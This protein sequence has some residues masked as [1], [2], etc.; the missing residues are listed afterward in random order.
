MYNFT[1]DRRTQ[2]VL[3]SACFVRGARHG[4][5]NNGLA[6]SSGNVFYRCTA[7]GSGGSEGGHRQWTT[8][9]LYDNVV[10]ADATAQILFD[11]PA[12]ELW[13]NLLPPTIPQPSLN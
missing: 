12:E 4:F 1:C 7:E 11:T 10:D 13:L 8:G 3:F 2:L 6:Y 5:E 9:I